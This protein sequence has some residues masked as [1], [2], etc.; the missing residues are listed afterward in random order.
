MLMKSVI[1][2]LAHVSGWQR[3]CM[4]VLLLVHGINKCT[5]ATPKANDWRLDYSVDYDN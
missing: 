2:S 1:I 3:K 4:I 5:H